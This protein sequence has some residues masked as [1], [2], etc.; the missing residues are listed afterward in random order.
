M[1]LFYNHW[2]PPSGPVLPQL[3]LILTVVRRK[4]EKGIRKEKCRREN[5]RE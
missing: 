5:E 3:L 2:L 4:V 1:S